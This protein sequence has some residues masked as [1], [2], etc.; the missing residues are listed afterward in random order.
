MT[1][2]S[3]ISVNNRNIYFK[4]NGAINGDIITV[5][6]LIVWEDDKS[7]IDDL[8]ISNQFTSGNHLP[9]GD[10]KATNQHYD[11]TTGIYW[12][13][14]KLKPITDPINV[15]LF[16]TG[17]VSGIHFP[18]CFDFNLAGPSPLVVSTAKFNGS[19][20]EFDVSAST[21]RL[22]RY[23]L[24]LLAV[25]EIDGNAEALPSKEK[26]IPYSFHVP[27]SNNSQETYAVMG[28]AEVDHV[29][30]NFV[31]R[32]TVSTNDGVLSL[33]QI[34]ENLIS[35]TIKLAKVSTHVDIALPIRFQFQNGTY[36]IVNKVDNFTVLGNNVTFNFPVSDIK[37]V[38]DLT[39]QFHL[40]EGD[41]NVPIF[42]KGKTSVKRW[43]HGQSKIRLVVDN[44]IYKKNLHSLYMSAFWEDGTP[45]TWFSLDNL[46]PNADWDV[47]HNNIV[48]RRSVTVDVFKKTTLTLSGEVD[49]SAYG[50]DE[51]FPFSESLDVGSDVIP[52][53]MVS[54]LGTV[55]QDQIWFQIT[56]R[57]NNGDIFKDASLK[58][59]N[60]ITN[61]NDQ[62]Y[63]EAQGML[64]FSV[65]NTAIDVKK[66]HAIIDIQLDLT[67]D[68]V[69]KYNYKG[70]IKIDVPYCV[71]SDTPTCSY[72]KDVVNGGILVDVVWALK[73][74][75]GN[76]PK[77]VN[78]TQ[79]IKNGAQT[80]YTVSYNQGSGLLTITTPV[81]LTDN[82]T[83]YIEPTVAASGFGTF[84]TLP[85]LD[86]KY[87]VPGRVTYDGHEFRNGKVAVYFKVRGWLGYYP[88]TVQLDN[89]SW[90][91]QLGVKLGTTYS[92]YDNST[93]I[94]TVVFDIFDPDAEVFS[95]ET[96]MKMD[97]GDF[98]IYP[99][100]F[101]FTR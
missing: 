98:T 43:G 61:I 99:V 28:Q 62:S 73:G 21:G 88:D 34:D 44:Q 18:V 49:L 59:F 29:K 5:A 9:F 6:S 92:E 30:H 57:Q 64:S 48:I 101:S 10:L 52:A 82:S 36:G 69:Y 97:L 91:K 68:S 83:L 40:T 81:N 32:T 74:S 19:K 11:K 80:E 71:T 95:A 45:V 50:I 70:S 51:R 8:V 4:T 58:S 39:V 24:G 46:N 84:V 65:S 67:S 3:Q 55:I 16:A 54:G 15:V 17:I 2:R 87:D 100:S 12:F 78:V 53:R 41:N 63:D 94:M 31:I 33:S 75:D 20:M 38:E 72:R 23:P 56:V 35:A 22:L 85:G 47:T 93:G 37:R 76:F 66:E 14:V 1:N 89:R 77:S 26:K 79:V 27:I 86:V 25:R 42:F 60:G 7:P 13:D 90:N 96:E